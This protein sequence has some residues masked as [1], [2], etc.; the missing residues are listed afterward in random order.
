MRVWVA[1]LLIGGAAHEQ[2]D[3]HPNVFLYWL[4]CVSVFTET[5][6]AI[7]LLSR[8]DFNPVAIWI[9]DEVNAHSLVFVA[10]YVLL[11]VLLMELFVLV[12]YKG[13]MK[14]AFAKVVWLSAVAEPGEL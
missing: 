4:A 2:K 5:Y 12:R 1:V 7:L 14:F 8:H 6:C 10:D 9:G 11:L 13:Q 3:F